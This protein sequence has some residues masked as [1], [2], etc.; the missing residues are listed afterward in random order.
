[1][2]EPVSGTGRYTLQNDEITGRYYLLS[3]IKSAPGATEQGGMT[4]LDL[5]KHVVGR[6]E[7]LQV[8]DLDSN[9]PFL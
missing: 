8:D 3:R 4:S 1:L 2:L 5:H 9:A 6:Q 7:V